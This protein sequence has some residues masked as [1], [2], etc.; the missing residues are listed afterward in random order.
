MITITTL[1][2]GGEATF[3]SWFC[4]EPFACYG[5]AARSVNMKMPNRANDTCGLGKVG[6]NMSV[7]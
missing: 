5:A 1:A 3:V 4:M 2:A 6:G 7:A